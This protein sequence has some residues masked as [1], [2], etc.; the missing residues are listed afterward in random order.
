[1]LGLQRVVNNVKFYFN[2]H[3][4]VCFKAIQTNTKCTSFNVN[5]IVYTFF[6][7]FR[8]R[9]K[10][11]KHCTSRPRVL[12]LKITLC[13]VALTQQ[14]SMKWHTHSVLLE[15]HFDTKNT[16]TVILFNDCT[17]TCMYYNYTKDSSPGGGEVLSTKDPTGMCR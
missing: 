13:T 8:F 9:I 11:Q 15:W 2:R 12:P 10:E 17:C 3:W 6:V 7:N 5:H 4:Q 14:Y 1:M 16:V